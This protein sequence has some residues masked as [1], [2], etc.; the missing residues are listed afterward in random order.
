MAGVMLS[1]LLMLLPLA[2]LSWRMDGLD[3]RRR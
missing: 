1:Q 3:G 2:L